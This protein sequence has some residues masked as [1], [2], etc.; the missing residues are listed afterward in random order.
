MP[1]VYLKSVRMSLSAASMAPMSFPENEIKFDVLI[2][3]VKS[4]V[5]NVLQNDVRRRIPMIFPKPYPSSL[6][7]TT[8]QRSRPRSISSSTLLVTSELLLFPVT[9]PEKS[10]PDDVAA[11][12]TFGDVIGDDDVVVPFGDVVAEE[13]EEEEVAVAV[14]AVGGFERAGFVGVELVTIVKQR[15]LNEM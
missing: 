10:V 7:W 2:T 15:S 4:A 12:V 14:A 5:L 3:D 11:A 13:E 1:G 8:T 9:S 6:S